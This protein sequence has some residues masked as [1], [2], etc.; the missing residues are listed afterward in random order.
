[1]DLKET[2]ES[3]RAIKGGE[4][5]SRYRALRNL[6]CDPLTAGF[7]AFMNCVAG[8]PAREIHFMNVVI[9]LED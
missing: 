6:G 8:V 9:E 3:S 1:M 7:I 4:A 2:G 5:V